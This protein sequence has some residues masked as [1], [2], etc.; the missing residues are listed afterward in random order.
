MNW[1]RAASVSA[2]L[3]VLAGCISLAGSQEATS[4]RI[5]VSDDAMRGV[6][7][8]KVAPVYPPLARQA[9]IQGTVILKVV[10]DKSGNVLEV[11]PVSGHPM[12]AP[13]AVDA[14]RQWK[15]Q[16]YLVNGEPVEVETDV[17]VIFKIEGEPAPPTPAENAPGTGPG[18]VP[19][20]VPGAGPALP[21]V[22]IIGG[23][24]QAT[25]GDSNAPALPKRIRVS[26]GVARQ[27]LISKVNPEY[28]PDAREQGVQGVVFLKVNIDKEGNVYRAEL[29]SGHPLLAPAAI[30]AVKQWKYKPFLLNG[31][32]IEVETQIQVNFTLTE[33]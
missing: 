8:K 13:A 24:V 21:Q 32:A 17:Q 11:R 6:L 15:Y 30:E 4:G 29:I 23:I 33:K 3:G 26:S 2:W 31:Q 7:V 1:L 9:R 19:G 10:I 16:P 25:P 12:L 20:G 14:V 28:P 22:G 18:E 27:L 5:T